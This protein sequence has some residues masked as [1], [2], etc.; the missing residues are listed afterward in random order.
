ML[1]EQFY[2]LCAAKYCPHTLCTHKNSLQKIPIVGLALVNLVGVQTKCC[3]P[4]IKPRTTYGRGCGFESHS[5]HTQHTPCGTIMSAS[6]LCTKTA[7]KKYQLWVWLLHIY[8]ESKLNETKCPS[9]GIEPGTT[10][11]RGCGFESHSNNTQQLLPREAQCQ[12]NLHL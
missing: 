10:K 12:I 2:F 6:A 4:V 8:Q 9:P 3:I 1:R 5:N 7:C 11:G